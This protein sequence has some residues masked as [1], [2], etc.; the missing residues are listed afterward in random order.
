[1]SSDSGKDS[2]YQAENV[3]VAYDDQQGLRAGNRDVEAFGVAQETQIVY[4]V[5][6]Q[7]FIVWAN[8]REESK[9]Q[10]LELWTFVVSALDPRKC[11]LNSWC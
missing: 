1:M 8:L 2:T 5:K 10:S 4:H 3:R 11:K 7:Q 6:G 9:V